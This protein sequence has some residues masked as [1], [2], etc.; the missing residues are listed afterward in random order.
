[1]PRP[2]RREPS[3]FQPF[4]VHAV[5]W[6][7]FALAA[8][9]LLLVSATFRPAENTAPAER[10]RMAPGFTVSTLDGRTL[11][12]EKLHGKAVIV[13]FWATWCGP[14]RFAMPHLQT[15]QDRYGKEGLVVIGVSVD[16]IGTE[17]VQK[18]VDRLGVTFPIGMANEEMLVAY[19]PLRAL[20]TT[21]FIDR[22][23]D[24]A[25]RVVGY[26]DEQTLE[27]YVKEILAK[28]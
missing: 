12:Q 8:A 14:C 2:G 13:D 3:A 27:V 10:A 7:R 18:F 4:E 24:I 5:K 6:Q 28:K 20:P 19:G 23:G 1:V 16:D 26:I 25:R 22:N 9:P 17:R 21:Y 11:K 15:M